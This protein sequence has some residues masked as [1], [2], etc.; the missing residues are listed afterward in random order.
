MLTVERTLYEC[1]YSERDRDLR[2]QNTDACVFAR[3]KS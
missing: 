1:K 3:N 2:V